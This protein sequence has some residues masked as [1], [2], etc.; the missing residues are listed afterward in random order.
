MISNLLFPWI[1]PDRICC[2][3]VLFA[4]QVFFCQA[5]KMRKKNEGESK[6]Q[7]TKFNMI[8]VNI[9]EHFSHSYNFSNKHQIIAFLFE[10]THHSF[11][12]NLFNTQKQFILWIICYEYRHDI[13]VCSPPGKIFFCISLFSL[14][15]AVLEQE[16]ATHRICCD[17]GHTW[18]CDGV[19]HNCRY[20]MTISCKG[21][22]SALHYPY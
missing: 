6:Y 13:T 1:F 8:H 5:I 14:N 15:D 18:F 17:L 21:L 2:R 9:S 19:C 7:G 4:V 20:D 22:C 12:N 16:N 11:L 10:A 3:A